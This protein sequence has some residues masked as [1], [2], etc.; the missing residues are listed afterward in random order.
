MATSPSEEEVAAVV[1]AI[2][3]VWPRPTAPAAEP[4]RPAWRFSGRWWQSRPS[5]ATQR[6][7]P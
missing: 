3:V 1:A 6:R 2:E 7:R 4:P 5:V